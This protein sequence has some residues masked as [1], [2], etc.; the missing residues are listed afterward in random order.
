MWNHGP[1][2]CFKRF[3]G[4]FFS[5][6]GFQVC[7]AKK[8]KPRSFIPQPRGVSRSQGVLFGVPIIR[9]IIAFGVLYWGPRCL[10]NYHLHLARRFRASGLGV[11]VEGSWI[12]TS[13]W[14]S[15]GQGPIGDDTW[16][17]VADAWASAAKKLSSHVTSNLH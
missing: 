8:C 2:G 9:I 7:S 17:Y 1:L 4:F 6:F 15:M 3:C 5:Y 10:G 14:V 13:R 16:R 11:C 12:L